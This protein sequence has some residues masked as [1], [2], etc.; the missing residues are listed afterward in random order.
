MRRIAWLTAGAVLATVIALLLAE[1]V[2]EVVAY[3]LIILALLFAAFFAIGPLRPS[4]HIEWKPVTAHLT[5]TN[6]PPQLQRLEWMVDFATTASAD[7]ELRL[8]PELRD[9]AAARLQE[10]HRLDLY[11]ARDEAAALLGTEVWEHLNPRRPRRFGRSALSLEEVDAI[12]TA[13]E[14]L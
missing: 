9:L 4:E 2:V 1:G 13:I 11:T 12:V 3:E 7:A 10:R 6:V 14:E 8:V 5:A